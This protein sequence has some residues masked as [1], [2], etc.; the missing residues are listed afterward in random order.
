MSRVL[1]DTFTGSAPYANV[2]L[3]TMHP[4]FWVRLLWEIALG[5]WR[6]NP[7]P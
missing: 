2:L 7:K 5:M 3:R 1:W 4:A 6:T